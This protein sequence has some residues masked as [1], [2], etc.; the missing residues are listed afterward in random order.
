MMLKALSARDLATSSIKVI[1]D[2]KIG[3]CVITEQVTV[4]YWSD[5]LS[6]LLHFCLFK[7]L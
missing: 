6:H 7:N 4:F 2:L 3:L 5:Y 1:P